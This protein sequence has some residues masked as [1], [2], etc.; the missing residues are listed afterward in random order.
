MRQ[1]QKKKF[2]ATRFFK[3]LSTSE[4][5]E[6][7]ASFP[8]HLRNEDGVPTK[9]LDEIL[10]RIKLSS[11]E[12]M[13]R[14]ECHVLRDAADVAFAWCIFERHVAFQR[15]HILLFA[16]DTK[17]APFL[18]ITAI[19]ALEEIIHQHAL[20]NEDYSFTAFMTE[21]MFDIYRHIRKKFFDTIS[22]LP[23]FYPVGDDRQSGYFGYRPP[24]NGIVSD[25]EISSG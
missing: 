13:E 5:R 6:E 18:N 1:A 20:D 15:L 25:V 22:H 16:L 17:R 11:E 12:D 2:R 9:L 8:D 7:F 21:S 3:R 14:L 23:D 4:A 24:Q 19:K 10:S